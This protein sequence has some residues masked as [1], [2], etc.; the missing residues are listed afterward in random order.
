MRGNQKNKN[1]IIKWTP[2]FAY[3]I[4]L[5]TTDGSLSIDGRH[6]NFTSKDKELVETFCKCL[7]LKN[8]IGRKSRGGEKEKKY[9]QVQF[10]NVKLYRWLEKIGLTPHKSKTIS[11][12]KIPNKY[13]FDFLRGHFDGDGSCFSFW[14]KRWLNSFMFYTYFISSSVSHLKWL[15]SRIESL[16]K[17]RGSIREYTKGTW[18][19]QYAK[20][21]SQILW[22]K[23]Y[24]KKDIPCLLRKR[25]KIENILKIQAQVAELADAAA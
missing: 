7:K 22:K 25:R 14:D 13:F 2:E 1:Y 10:G 21:S 15:H 4:G 18:R 9:Y 19:M 17:V 11:A 6:I 20:R 23:M 16:A 3:A 24:Y 5:L 8:K 12:L